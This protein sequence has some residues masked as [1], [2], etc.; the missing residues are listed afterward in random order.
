MQVFEQTCYPR[1]MTPPHPRNLTSTDIR[2]AAALSC[3]AGWNQTTDDWSLLLDLEPLHCW[4]I[5]MEGVLAATTTLVCYERRLA[6][7]GMVLTHPD[8][9]RRGLA[10][11]LVE[12]ALQVANDLRS[13]A[14]PARRREVW[15]GSAAHVPS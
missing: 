15:A 14:G 10:R 7:L 4:G 2:Q 11:R 1:T 12:H 8:Y 3:L 13:H 6:W 9:R 5:E